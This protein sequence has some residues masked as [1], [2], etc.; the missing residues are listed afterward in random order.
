[1]RI[2]DLAFMLAVLAT[3]CGR[4]VFNPVGTPWN[5]QHRHEE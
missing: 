1:M 2:S 3:F 4:S 5:Q